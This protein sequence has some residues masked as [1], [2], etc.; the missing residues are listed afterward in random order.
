M[1]ASPAS[2]HS[3]GMACP[4][5]RS[6]C[7]VSA[8]ADVACGCSGPGRLIVEH[9]APKPTDRYVALAQLITAGMIRRTTD[10]DGRANLTLTATGRDAISRLTDARRE[11]LANLL[12]GYSPDEVP[13][14]SELLHRLARQLLADDA[15][16]RDAQSVTLARR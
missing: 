15:L 2:V 4:A 12:D 10:A 7:P 14:L 6:R 3:Q 11:G 1:R 8:A 5:V 13:E 9:T 16:I